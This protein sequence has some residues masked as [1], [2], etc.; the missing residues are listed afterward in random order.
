MKKIIIAIVL[1][2]AGVSLHYI[3]LEPQRPAAGHAVKSISNA[4]FQVRVEQN[5]G[6]IKT[7]VT[8][9]GFLYITVANDGADKTPMATA[10]ARQAT[11]SKAYGIKAVK[12][13]DAAGN[14]LGKAF[15]N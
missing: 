6:I 12:V 4:A 3:L 8:T 5:T 10:Y 11:E 9:Q 15:C 2:A 1:V 14:E 7:D 13:V